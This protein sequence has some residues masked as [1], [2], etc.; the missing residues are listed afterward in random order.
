[1]KYQEL[2]VLLPCHSLEDFPLYHDGEEAEGLLATWTALWHPQLILSAGKVPNW[3]R[4]DDPPEEMKDRLIL[5]PSVCESQL[6]AGWA[7][8]AKKEGAIVLRKQSKRAMLLEKAL[9]ELDETPEISSAWV[10]DFLAFGFC[11]L[12]TELLVRQL[13][14]Y[15]SLDEVYIQ[16]EILLAIKAVVEGDEEKGKK[17]LTN[18]F[19][20]LYECREHCYPSTLYLIDIT[21]T[22]KNFLG[23]E[24]QEELKSTRRTNLLFEGE[25]LKDLAADFPESLEAVQQALEEKQ[26][27]LLGGDFAERDLPLLPLES[28]LWGL[29]KGRAAFQEAFGQTPSIYARRRYGLDPLLPQVLNGLGYEGALHFTLDDGRFPKLD[30]SKSRWEGI[31]A[32]GI[33]CLSRVPLDASDATSFL[34]LPERLAESIDLDHVAT[35]TFAHWPGQV[36]EYYFDL[37]NSVKYAPVLG[38]YTDLDYYFKKTEVPGSLGLYPPDQYRSPYLKQAIR[39]RKADPLTS[40]RQHYQRQA[41]LTEAQTLLTL[42]DLL[43]GQIDDTDE[44]NQQVQLVDLT[45]R[46]AGPFLEE[47]E[48]NLDEKIESHLQSSA[49][50]FLK[51]LPRREETDT[52]GVYLI[53]PHS[54]ARRQGMIIPGFAHAPAAEGPIR[55]SQLLEQ[56]SEDGRPQVAV[57]VDIPAMGYV[58]IP[59]PKQAPPK[60]STPK[61]L[62]EEN[63]LRNEYYEVHFDAVTGAI[64]AVHDYVHRGIRLSQQLA[65]RLPT[66]RPR[67]GDP[68]QDPGEAAQYSVMKADR[69]QITENGP[70]LGEIQSIGSLLDREG[71]QLAKYVQT[72]RVWRASRLLEIEIHLEPE[73]VPRADPWNSYYCSRFAWSDSACDYYRGTPGGSQETKATQLEAPY[74]F[75]AR[76]AQDRTLVVTEGM[77]F[78]LRTTMRTLDMILS[79]RGDR[80]QDFRCQTGLDVEQPMLAAGQALH[81]V[82]LIE[83]NGP[84]P[85]AGHTSWFFHLNRKNVQITHW[86]P[87]K[88]DGKLAGVTVRMLE[89][90]G[91]AADLK[92]RCYRDPQA[93]HRTDYLGNRQEE[94]KLEGDVVSVPLQARDFAQIEIEWT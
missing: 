85:L 73:E 10:D 43:A 32:S 49:K 22:A 88:R 6:Q 76:G 19:N 17:H 47:F 62:A 30:Q 68:W 40:Y 42:A 77:P 46:S 16:D 84:P 41:K 66:P 35:V 52:P 58:W 15:V 14:Q 45:E 37:Q 54:S 91:R 2:V 23:K 87:L 65:F 1:M 44:Q 18:A 81:P 59:Q 11:Y 4:A 79:V 93:A 53:N 26:V 55:A 5:V 80:G 12:Q 36:S 90:E 34:K 29:N 13:R 72:T 94:L 24:L 50:K 78:H 51:H 21:L 27:D 83:E 9:A 33:D 31:H 61:P 38:E 48:A 60:Q 69:V 39:R 82:L 86:E 8:R 74:F 67:P 57:V 89:T 28:T 70:A 92:L 56:K 64:R 71:K 63:L 25:L 75:E 3:Y 20:T 7:A